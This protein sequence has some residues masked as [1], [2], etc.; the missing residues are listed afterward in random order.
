M[1]FFLAGSTKF[2]HVPTLGTFPIVLL[3][4]PFTHP[5]T[6]PS[7]TF[8]VH[9]TMH[10]KESYRTGTSSYISDFQLGRHLSCHLTCIKCLR[11]NNN[12]DL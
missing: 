5:T 9:V 8:N 10:Y 12:T 2:Y 7:K 3:L 11:I 1:L 4:I 6:F